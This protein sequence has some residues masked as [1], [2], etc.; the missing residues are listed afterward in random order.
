MDN[1]TSYSDS[2]IWGPVMWFNIHRVA[3]EAITKEL[4]E[5]FINYITVTVNKLPCETCK[6][7][8]MKYVEQNHPDMYSKLKDN[9]GEYNGMF[10]WTWIFH[11]AVNSRLNKT[12]IDYKTAFNMYED[13]GICSDICGE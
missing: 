9:Q 3:K 8:A 5:E 11:N 1:H 2:K 7:H 12:I 6:I 13:S 4:I 10:K